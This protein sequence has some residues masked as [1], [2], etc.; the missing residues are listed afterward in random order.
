[1]ARLLLR[2]AGAGAAL[3]LVI[4]LG[5]SAAAAATSLG[6]KLRSGDTVLVPANETVD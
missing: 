1:M 6:G 2:F 3:L 4:A 5:V